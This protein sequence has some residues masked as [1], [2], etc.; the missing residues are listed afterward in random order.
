MDDRLLEPD[1]IQAVIAAL[2]AGQVYWFSWHQEM[3]ER[4]RFS[5][6]RIEQCFA[7]IDVVYEHGWEG[8]EPSHVYTEEEYAQKL[9][10][11]DLKYYSHF[12]ERAQG[13]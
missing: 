12:L 8:I 4:T 7:K 1:E 10:G 9:S 2:K 6:G 13:R 11:T 3:E 5:S